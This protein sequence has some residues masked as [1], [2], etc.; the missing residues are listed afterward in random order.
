[1]AF[2]T[3]PKSAPLLLP[4]DLEDAAAGRVDSL[5][6]FVDASA[7]LQRYCGRRFDERRAV[8]KYA[9]RR[10][11]DGGDLFDASTLLV[12]EDDLRTVLALAKNVPADA[13]SINDGTAIA[14]GSYVTPGRRSSDDPITRISLIY[15][16]FNEGIG[17]PADMQAI[18]IDGLWGWGGQWVSTGRTVSDNPLSSSATVLTPSNISGFEAGHVIRIDDEYLYVSAVG[19]STLTVVRAFNGTTAASHIAASPVLFWQADDQVRALVQR[20][21]LW[22]AEQVKSPAVGSVTIDGFSY[23]VDLNGLPK[24]VYQSINS[25]GLRRIAGVRSA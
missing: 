14:A 17:S 10:L 19:S 13:D 1:M 24:D 16:T 6:L 18:W 9:A 20:L 7:A 2:A 23:P 11:K 15:D 4:G 22:G 25:S 8:M 21:V 12:R 5:K 3:I